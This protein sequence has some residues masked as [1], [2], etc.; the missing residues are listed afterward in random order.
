MNR[1]VPAAG[2][3]DPL[4]ANI[5][6]SKSPALERIVGPGAQIRGQTPPR[7]VF[8]RPAF[9]AFFSQK[10]YFGPSRYYINTNDNNKAAYLNGNLKTEKQE[11]TTETKTQTPDVKV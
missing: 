1:G 10:K 3:S 7:S 8:P 5:P 2:N 4:E 9:T 11:L 6:Q